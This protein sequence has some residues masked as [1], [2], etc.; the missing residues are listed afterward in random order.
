[1]TDGT[2]GEASGTGTAIMVK[3][4]KRVLTISVP[5]PYRILNLHLVRL[6]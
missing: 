6:F 5:V 2:A 1:M 4:S 3:V